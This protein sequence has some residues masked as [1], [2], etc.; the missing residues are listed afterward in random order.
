MKGVAGWVTLG[1]TK[2]Q[3]REEMGAG[4]RDCM[5]PSPLPQRALPQEE[6]GDLLERQ[7]LMWKRSLAKLGR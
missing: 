3:V 7:S 2:H 5:G 1:G 4:T 6:T